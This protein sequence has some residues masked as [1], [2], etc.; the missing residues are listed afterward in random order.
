MPARADNKNTDFLG[1]P[2]FQEIVNQPSKTVQADAKK[3]D[4]N[5]ILKKANGGLGLVQHLQDVDAQFMDVSEHDDY[6]TLMRHVRDA[7]STF[8]QLP[9]K[10]RELFDHDV[11]KWLDAAHA[12]PG[13]N[14]A[15]LAEA[16]VDPATSADPAS[17]TSGATPDPAASASD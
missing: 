16:G 13:E 6:V 14:D 15:L 17:G 11:A 4:I 8:N 10:V 2:R 1:R 7:E 12:A 3:A 5:E 9:S